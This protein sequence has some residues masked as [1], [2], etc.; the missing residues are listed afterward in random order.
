MYRVYLFV[1]GICLCCPLIRA[2]EPL[3][4]PADPTPTVT[5]DMRQV[6]LQD[7]LLEIE[8]QTGIFFSYDERVPK[9]VSEST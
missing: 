4:L 5:L 2:K 6:P 9:S 7:I 8:R 3:P 1:F